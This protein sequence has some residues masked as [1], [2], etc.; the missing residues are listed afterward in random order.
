M[1]RPKTYNVPSSF[2]P[3]SYHRSS[4]QSIVPNLLLV[5]Q[6]RIPHVLPERRAFKSPHIY[7]TPRAE[8]CCRVPI[9]SLYSPTSAHQPAGKQATS[10]LGCPVLTCSVADQKFVKFKLSFVNRVQPMDWVWLNWQLNK[11]LNVIK[12]TCSTFC[13]CFIKL[14][15]V[16]KIWK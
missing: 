16:S 4:E 10:A 14:I 7:S 3:P 11:S 9:K 1:V 12:Y 5:E 8:I 13:V 2:P 15:I 6:K